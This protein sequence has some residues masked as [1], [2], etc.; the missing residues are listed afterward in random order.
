MTAASPR[1]GLD[2][3]LLFCD[4]G[5]GVGLGHRA[6]CEAIAKAPGIEMMT[7]ITDLFFWI[8]KIQKK[9]QP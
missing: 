6:R 5:P 4:E 7:P 2:G 8:I 3:V 1:L 9:L